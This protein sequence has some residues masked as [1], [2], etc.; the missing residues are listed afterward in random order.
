MRITIET[1]LLETHQLVE[2]Q[3]MFE[4]TRTAFPNPTDEF[5]IMFVHQA[6]R[7]INQ[8]QVAID[9]QREQ[10]KINGDPNANTF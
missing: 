3:E 5:E 7:I 8:L 9:E 4:E 2:L 1:N 10:T 6:T